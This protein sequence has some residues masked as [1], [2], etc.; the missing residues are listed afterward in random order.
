MKKFN[1]HSDAGHGWLAVKFDLL[2]ELN[3]L[4]DISEFSYIKGKTV[5][6][7]EDC[8]AG[9]FINAF[10][11]RFGLEPII[12]DLDQKGRSPIR[13]MHRFKSGGNHEN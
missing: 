6:L 10:K 1:F 11:I 5:Y 12:V 4:N 7:E 9:K 13:S 3:L 8:D 2:R